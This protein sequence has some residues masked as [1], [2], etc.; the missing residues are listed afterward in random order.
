MKQ[1]FQYI[2]KFLKN[3]L[4]I[5]KANKP[6]KLTLTQQQEFNNATSCYMCNVPFNEQVT[7]I[8]E[9]NHF[10]GKYRG[11][12]CQSCNTQEGKASKEIPVFFHNG[13]KYDFHFIVIELMKYQDRYNKV[14]VLPKTSEEY[15]SITYGSFYRKLIFKDSYRCLQQGLSDIAKSMTLED[16][17]IMADF[18]KDINLLKQKGVYPYEYID[19][20]EKLNETQLPPIEAFYSTL[21][22]ETIT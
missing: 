2:I 16:F 5:Q 9:H 18:Y 21:K 7:K 22:Q 14:E 1:L 8:R 20:L 10:N 17:K 19:S 4:N 11:A 13:S 6:V 15:I 3:F 12:A